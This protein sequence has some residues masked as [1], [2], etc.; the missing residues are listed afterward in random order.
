MLSC[1]TNKCKVSL[2]LTVEAALILLQP[3]WEPA[4]PKNCLIVPTVETW[5]QSPTPR[6]H[7]SVMFPTHFQPS[8]HMDCLLHSVVLH[9]AALLLQLGTL[10]VSF[11]TPG[12][13]AL[14]LLPK[15]SSCE[16]QSPLALGKQHTLADSMPTP[17]LWAPESPG[18]YVTSQSLATGTPW[19]LACPA[20][21]PEVSLP[22]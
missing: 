19:N 14:W 2:G 7:T 4:Y 21:V 22:P 10:L 16:P 3:V 11:C 6:S 1:R 12:N 17:H 13:Q 20:P 15:T 18:L 5:S 9:C 8:I